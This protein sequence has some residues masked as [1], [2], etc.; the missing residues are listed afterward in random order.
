VHPPLSPCSSLTHSRPQPMSYLAVDQHLSRGWAACSSRACLSRFSC[1]VDCLGR[2]CASGADA[3]TG[4][5]MLN[6]YF[7]TQR[8]P[9][10]AV[11][12]TPNI[13]VD[14]AASLPLLFLGAVSTHPSKTTRQR[15]P[16]SSFTRTTA[17][18]LTST[19]SDLHRHTVV[20]AS[21]ASPHSSERPSLPSPAQ[22]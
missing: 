5:S 7:A 16:G 8:V 18:N 3:G 6:S 4:L 15:S 11:L 10:S 2:S 21:Q 17:A 19:L 12:M 9:I 20:S 13:E 22:W 14:I 1:D